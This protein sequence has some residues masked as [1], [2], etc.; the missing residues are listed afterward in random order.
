MTRKKKSRKIGSGGNGSFRLSK[1]K[2][3]ELRALKEQRVKKRT[4]NKAGTRNAQEVMDEHNTSGK[5]RKDT[6]LGSKKPISLVPEAAAIEQQ[7]E[8]KRH[9]QPQVE[10]RKVVEPELTQEQ[11]LEQ[12]ENDQ[13]LMSLLERQNAGEVLVGKDAKYL[14]AKVA[15]HQTLCELLGI[16]DEDEFD[17]E[18]MLDQFM[19]NDLADEWL[20]DDDEEELK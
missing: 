7:P 14:N 17:D 10:L 19:S 9:L 8:F 11:E 6:R 13:K 16:E 18:D 12:I 3:A 20:N 2:L 1:E 15:R 4:G 5:Q